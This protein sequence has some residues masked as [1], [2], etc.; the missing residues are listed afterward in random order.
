MTAEDDYAADDGST[1]SQRELDATME[2]DQIANALRLQGQLMEA[3]RQVQTKVAHGGSRGLGRELLGQ[4]DELAQNY[5]ADSAAQLGKDM[6]SFIYSGSGAAAPR[7]ASASQS[8]TPSPAGPRALEGSRER[9]RV[10]RAKEDALMLDSN[11]PTSKL[12]EIRDRRRA[13]GELE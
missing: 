3:K 6:D 10:D 7:P 4:I 8:S 5:D 1:P 12:R 13:A 9:K 2:G 11:T